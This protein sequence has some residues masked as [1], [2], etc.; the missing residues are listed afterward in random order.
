MPQDRE[1]QFA[2]FRGVGRGRKARD[3]VEQAGSVEPAVECPGGV[4]EES[5]LL[6]QVDVDGAVEDLAQ[7]DVL[8]VGSHRSVER[9]QGDLMAGTL[10]R[11][12]ER[13][14]MDA[15]A[16]V[17]ARRAGC[18]RGHSHG[19]SPVCGEEADG[20]EADGGEVGG[21]KRSIRSAEGG[22]VASETTTRVRVEAATRAVTGIQPLPPR[23]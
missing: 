17:H 8:L 10:Q 1:G 19:V 20:E 3:L 23:V 4:P 14:V 11:G 12:R 2:K 13:V 21:K 18:D 16:A 6:L 15:G 5:R 9:Q 22:R 7:A